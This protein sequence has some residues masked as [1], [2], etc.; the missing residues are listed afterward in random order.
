MRGVSLEWKTVRI[1]EGFMDGG[2]IF[3][4][5]RRKRVSCDE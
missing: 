5:G 1:F 4:E 2:G 3:R